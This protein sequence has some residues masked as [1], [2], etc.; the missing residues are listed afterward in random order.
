MT[1]ESK[2]LPQTQ[3]L[4]DIE[5]VKA[6]F[7]RHGSHLV[8]AALA[9]LIAI[10]GFNLLRTRIER[11]AVEADSRLATAQS[12]TDLEAVIHDFAKTGAAP[13]A[14]LSLGK[15]HF[16]NG[17]YE[18]ALAQYERFLAQWPTHDMTKTAALGR[19]FCIEARGRQDAFEEAAAAFAAFASGNPGHYLQPQAVFGQARCLEQ[20]NRLEEAR[21]IYEDYIAAHPDSLWSMRAEELL[22]A[23]QRRIRRTA[24]DA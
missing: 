20:L 15:L 5:Q 23:I 14:L 19:I 18:A 8:T 10:T 3:Q 22:T 17:N 11:R 4:N 16:D 21:T 9:V 6:W 24:P 1:T 13:L 12:V 7:Q 2:P